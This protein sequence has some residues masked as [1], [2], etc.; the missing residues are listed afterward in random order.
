MREHRHWPM[1]GRTMALNRAPSLAPSVRQDERGYPREG[2]GVGNPIASLD[3]LGR[4]VRE[5]QA[6]EI[7]PR[8][9]RAV[10]FCRTPR[11]LSG[12]SA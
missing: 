2:K 11:V 8:L 10:C 7:E 3:A 5:T 1:S 9:C 12:I 4:T 6:V